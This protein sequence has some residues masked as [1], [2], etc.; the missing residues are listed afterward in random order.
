MKLQLTNICIAFINL[1]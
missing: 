1:C